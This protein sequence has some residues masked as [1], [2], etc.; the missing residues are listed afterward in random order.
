LIDPPARS[1]LQIGQEQLL[2]ARRTFTVPPTKSEVRDALR[3]FLVTKGAED[4]DYSLAD[5]SSVDDMALLMIDV[6]NLLFSQVALPLKERAFIMSIIGASRYARRDRDG[7][8]PLTDN[9]LAVRQI[10]NTKTRGANSLRCKVRR[11]RKAL[12]AWQQEN[13]TGLVEIRPGK[14]RLKRNEYG[15]IDINDKGQ[16]TLLGVPTHYRLPVVD[17]ALE[18]VRNYQI[19]RATTARQL[20]QMVKKMQ[21]R[22]G[23]LDKAPEPDIDLEKQARHLKIK[24]LSETRRLLNLSALSGEDKGSVLASLVIEIEAIADEVSYNDT[25]DGEP[26]LM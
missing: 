2:D 1:Y 25:T 9:N 23:L 26:Y 7:W 14:G 6:M 16:K 12:D 8:F 21:K 3:E 5:P 20:R 15:R 17:E 4:P 24:I 19:F 10:D 13:G 11:L 22:L 18:V